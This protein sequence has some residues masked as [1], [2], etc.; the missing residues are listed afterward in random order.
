LEQI[1]ADPKAYE[2]IEPVDHVGLQ[3]VD[4]LQIIKVP[5]DIST[6]RVIYKLR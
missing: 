5:M 3:L 4:Y 2:F 6:I 1:E